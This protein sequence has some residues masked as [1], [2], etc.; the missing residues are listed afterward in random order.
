[1][2]AFI[3]EIIMHGDCA[4]I[5]GKSHKINQDYAR[6]DNN[7]PLVLVSD[8]CSGSADTDFGS[9]ILVKT[10]ENLVKES[11]Y[12]GAFRPEID[13][14]YFWEERIIKQASKNAINI[15]MDLSCLDATLLSVVKDN[16]SISIR[17]FGDGLFAIKHAD[18]SME[19]DLITFP[20]GY[21]EYLSYRLDH[22]RTER[23]RK[24]TGENKYT[25]ERTVI[26]PDGNIISEFLGEFIPPVDVVSFILDENIESVFIMTDG[27]TSYMRKNATGQIEAVSY[28]DIVRRITDIKV[29][30]GEFVQRQMNGFVKECLKSGYYNVDDFTVGALYL[31]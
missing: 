1:M 9:R 24:E 15:D 17:M 28:I 14:P 19:C 22:T 30:T 5:V 8:G 20:S 16:N 12:K 18:G 25:I 2:P 13:K 23:L 31:K 29:Y 10:A 3:L 11:T 27:V 21:P 7:I 6:I 4:S 26:K